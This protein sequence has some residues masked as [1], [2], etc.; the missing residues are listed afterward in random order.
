MI[1][2]KIQF[3]EFLMNKILNDSV[4]FLLRHTVK[5]VIYNQQTRAVT[6]FYNEFTTLL[7]YTNGTAAVLSIQPVQFTQTIH[8]PL[9]TSVVIVCVVYAIHVSH[10]FGWFLIWYGMVM[11][12]ILSKFPLTATELSNTKLNIQ[13]CIYIIY[14]YK[15]LYTQSE[16]VL[17]HVLHIHIFCCIKLKMI[18]FETKIRQMELK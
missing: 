8:V 9:H 16:L 12:P 18:L 14:I 15:R 7:Y 13:Q 11:V 17:L 3:L 4:K 10:H 2:L 5:N 6:T 1:N